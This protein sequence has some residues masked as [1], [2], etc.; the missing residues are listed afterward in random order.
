MCVCVRVCVCACVCACVCVCVCACVCVCSHV[1][2]V[3]A[4]EKFLFV[5]A[6]TSTHQQPIG[7]P[8]SAHWQPIGNPFS[9]NPRKQREKPKKIKKFEKNQEN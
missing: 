5:I 1:W 2:C 8:S 6:R 9:F 7:K 4:Y 3:C